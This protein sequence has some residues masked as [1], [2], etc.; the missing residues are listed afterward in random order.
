MMIL[1]TIMN[2]I[3]I[4]NFI[5]ILAIAFLMNSCIRSMNS[6][7]YQES[8]ILEKIPNDDFKNYIQ[9]DEFNST[10]NLNNILYIDNINTE[11]EHAAPPFFPGCLCSRKI[12]IGKNKIFIFRMAPGFWGYEAHY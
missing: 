2:N 12:A 6:Y 3:K 1:V 4:K 9:S 10:Y 11:V 7:R 8:G 5:F